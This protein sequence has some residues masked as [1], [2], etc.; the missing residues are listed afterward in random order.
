[1]VPATVCPRRPQGVDAEEDSFSAQGVMA[2]LTERFAAQHGPARRRFSA[3]EHIA[4]AGQ[5]GA[6]SKAWSS[7]G[8][9]APLARS[10]TA[11]LPDTASQPAAEGSYASTAPAAEASYGAPADEGSFVSMDGR[12]KHVTIPTSH[13]RLSHV[14][15]ALPTSLEPSPRGGPSMMSSLSSHLD[16]PGGAEASPPRRRGL[17]RGISWR[18]ANEVLSPSH[19]AGEPAAAPAGRPRRRGSL[20]SVSEK[21]LGTGGRQRRN[22]IQEAWVASPTGLGA[23]PRLFPCLVHQPAPMKPMPRSWQQAGASLP[24]LAAQGAQLAEA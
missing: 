17:A 20:R 3:L 1:M 7:S 13:R 22:S 9:M 16:S 4:A 18:A 23:P 10:P 14:A 15:M 21:S 19:A 24:A 11:P 8:T 2:R 6:L 5:Q 12:V